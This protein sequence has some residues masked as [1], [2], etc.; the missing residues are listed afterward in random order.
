VMKRP[1][2]R[3][4]K[5]AASAGIAGMIGAKNPAV[6]VEVDDAK[7]E[8]LTKNDLIGT[9]AAVARAKT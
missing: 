8:I 6:L 3:I 5:A 9:I 2:P 1:L 7:F 4:S